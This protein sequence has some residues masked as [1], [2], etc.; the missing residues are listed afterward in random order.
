MRQHWT[1][2]HTPSSSS[3][4][5]SRHARLAAAAE[6]ALPSAVAAALAAPV[7][8][9]A[10]VAALAEAP[11]CVTCM[12]QAQSNWQLAGMGLTPVTAHCLY[13]LPISAVCRPKDGSLPLRKGTRV[14]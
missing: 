2:A 5:S 4:S 6:A 9:A 1:G 12:E 3:S 13:E 7:C 11:G 14:Y 8:T 10:A